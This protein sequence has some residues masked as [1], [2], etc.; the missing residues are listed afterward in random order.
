MDFVNQIW[1]AWNNQWAANIATIL[2]I[3]AIAMSAG[4]RLH[5]FTS[6]ITHWK[7]WAIVDRW[8]RSGQRKYRVRRAKNSM[9]SKLEQTGV[10]ISIRAYENCL[11]QNQHTSER[12]ALSNITPEKPSWLNDYYVASALESL[13]REC[14]IMKAMIF[15]LNSFPPRPVS[16]LFQDRKVGTTAKKQA[17]EIETEG[18]CLVYQTFRECLETNRYE[19]SGH[20][21][22]V[23]P[24]SVR[25]VPEFRLKGEAP[26]CIR[27]WE[28]KERQSDIR[29]LVDDITRYD[30]AT[31]A[32]IKITGGNREFQEAVIA[33]CLECQCAAEVA[34]VKNIVERAIE[35]R[36]SQ[37]GN[38]PAGN[39][40]DWTEELTSDFTSGL[41]AYIEAE[42]E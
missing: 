29:L 33:T 38:L 6:A 25:H 16:Y 27:C 1:T 19:S 20:S 4:D 2:S 26:Q 17:D 5:R 40:M 31:T 41:R 14:K 11:T 10:T 18:K 34:L 23:A 3:I 7:G 15:E 35:I 8:Y 22:T 28:I 37:L 32:T 39:K 36:G 30:L 21:E 12:D 9:R 24:G 13:S 42:A